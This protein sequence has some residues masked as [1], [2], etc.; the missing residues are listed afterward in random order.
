MLV[1]EEQNRRLRDGRRRWRQTAARAKAQVL[2]DQGEL[3]ADLRVELQDSLQRRQAR[4]AASGSQ[5]GGRVARPRAEPRS[6][7]SILGG[8]DVAPEP[9]EI[10]LHHRE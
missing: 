2:G 6:D 4:P 5:A 7:T 1:G 10:L 8:A 3:V 9:S